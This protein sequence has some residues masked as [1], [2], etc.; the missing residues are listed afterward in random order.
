VVFSK[1]LKAVKSQLKPWDYVKAGTLMSAQLVIWFG[2]DGVAF[3]GEVA[4]SIMSAGTLIQDSLKVNVVCP[5]A[6]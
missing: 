2:T 6:G 4:L 1:A 5:R 3:V